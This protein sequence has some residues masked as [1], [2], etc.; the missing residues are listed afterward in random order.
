MCKPAYAS[1]DLIDQT[2][3]AS[4]SS[5]ATRTMSNPFPSTSTS[6]A[7]SEDQ[8]ELTFDQ[9]DPRIHFAQTT[10]KW[11][12]END[13]GSELEWDLIRMV[14]VPVLSDT[15]LDQQ[16]EAYKVEGVDAS[17]C[18]FFLRLLQALSEANLCGA[19]SIGTSRTSPVPG[20]KE[21]KRQRFCRLY[22]QQET[23]KG[24][25][26]SSQYCNLH[27]LS[28]TVH[29]TRPPPERLLKSWFDSRRCVG[30]SSN[31]IILQQ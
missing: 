30:R 22:R 31:Q 14:W 13:D 17:V 10:G 27:N 7:S 24:K 20:I 1:S 15:L 19:R 9:S 5:T 12:F 28:S 3:N 29:H 2:L 25:T 4:T 18:C 11:T 16:Q 8:P 26:S 21:E 6:S 23:Q